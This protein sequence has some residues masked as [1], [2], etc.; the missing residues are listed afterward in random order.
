MGASTP[1]SE[2]VIWEQSGFV[3]GVIGPGGL[4]ERNQ[5]DRRSKTELI[6]IARSMSTEPPIQST[7]Q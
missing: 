3:Y 5:T 6:N 2:A 7:R 1:S 4:D